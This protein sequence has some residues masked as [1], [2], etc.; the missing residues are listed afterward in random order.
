MTM[1]RERSRSVGRPARI[2]REDIADAALEIGLHA[3]TVKTI[4]GRLG[5]DH[6]SLYRHVKGRD[7]IVF[8]AADRAIATLDWERETDDWRDY[9]HAAAEAVWELYNCNPGLAAAMRNMDKTP[10]AGIR[11]F[12]RACR[13][14]EAEGFD[15]EDAAL[16]MDSVMDMTSDSASMWER[17][18]REDA[19]GTIA[20]RLKASWQSGADDQTAAHVRVMGAV[21]EG[22]PKDWWRK[23]LLLLI[24]GAATL[25]ETRSSGSNTSQ[26]EK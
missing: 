25:L 15:T 4:A 5:V 11:A 24:G 3:A 1:G 20:E 8:A 10:P 21:I 12:S 2:S 14:L 17:L 22:N 18:R 23:K 7:D 6:S 13:Y 9:I 16:I 26:K 19:D